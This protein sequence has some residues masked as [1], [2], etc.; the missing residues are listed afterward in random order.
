MI[1]PTQPTTLP[2]YC[3]DIEYFTLDDETRNENYGR[4]DPD[5]FCDSIHCDRPSPGWH[6]TNWYRWV[7]STDERTDVSLETHF[8]FELPIWG[9]F[10]T[11]YL[12]E[13][14]VNPF[15]SPFSSLDVN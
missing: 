3:S 13:S 6:G 2:D 10:F 8:Q 14:A 12:L 9:F 11:F 7:S 5:Y 1:A 15:K 4:D